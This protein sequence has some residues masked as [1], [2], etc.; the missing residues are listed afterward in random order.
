MRRRGYFRRHLAVCAAVSA[1]AL[2]VPGAALAATDGD[3]EPIPN[4]STLSE[5]AQLEGEPALLQRL[6]IPGSP[7]DDSPEAL[8]A[9]GSPDGPEDDLASL[10]AELA[11]AGT[12]E[13]AREARR[14][15]LDVLEGAPLDRAY[16]GIPLLNWNS[17]AKVK[18][19]PAGGSVTVRQVRFGEHLVSD[20]WLLRFDD[21]DAPFRIVYE[22]AELAGA[23]GG[24]LMP[25]PLL[26][27]PAAPLGG[28]HSIVEPLA[29]PGLATGTSETSR[30]HPDGEAEQTRVGL[31]RLTV[32]MPPP[33]HVHMLLDPSLKPG[34]E[35]LATLAPATPERIASAEAALGFSGD[36]PSEAQRREAISR[37][38]ARAPERQIWEALDALD[39]DAG[40][41]RAAAR[42]AAEGALPL[43]GAMRSRS[44]LPPGVTPEPGADVTVALLNNEAYVSRRGL[45]LEPG[46]ELRVAVVNHDGFPHRVNALELRGRRPVFGPTG[47]GEFDWGPAAG[48]TELAPGESATLTLRPSEGAFALW[49]GDQGTGDQAAATI[50]LDRGPRTQSIGFADDFTAPRHVAEDPDGRLW[51][52]LEGIDTI[53][54]ITPATDLQESGREEYPL[55]GGAYRPDSAQPPLGP[56]DVFVDGHG[57]VWVTLTLG[58]AIARIDPSLTEDGTSKGIRIYELDPCPPD[59]GDTVCREEFPPDAGGPT[60]GPLQL[61]GMLDAEG[62]TTLFFTEM[63]VDHIGVLRVAP[64]GAKLNQ[65]DVPCNCLV[66]LGIGLGADGAVWFTEG[67]TN[68]IGRLRLSRARPFTPSTAR[69][70]HFPIPF[71]TEVQDP[72]HPEPVFT[73]AP[74]S[75]AIDPEG[76]V[77]FTG[78]AVAKVAYLDPAQARAGTSIGFRSFDTGHSAYGGLTAPADLAADRGGT[79]YWTDEYGDIV[80]S[81][82]A[83]GAGRS[84]RPAERR[85]LTDSAMVDS[86]GNL[87]FLELGSNLLTRISG[88]SE[89]A[90]GPAPQPVLEALS[91]DDV[92]RGSRLREVSSVDVSVLRAGRVV[93]AAAAPVSGG[94]FEVGEGQW[95]GSSAGDALRGGDV[96]R[97]TPRAAH[98]RAAVEFTVA[99]LTGRVNS[100]RALTGSAR[101]G[102]DPLGGRLEAVVAGTPVR[103][104]IDPDDGS[105]AKVLNEGTGPG[106]TGT[107]SWA[108]ATAAAIFR[109][110]TRFPETAPPP[111]DDDDRDAGGPG[112]PPAGGGDD[113]G[114]DDDSWNDDDDRDDAGRPSGS[115]GRSCG[116][117]WL[118]GSGRGARVQLLG[119]SE[120]SVTRCLGRPA[121]RSVRGGVVRLRYP[122]RL[123]VSLRGGRAVGFELLA[124]GLRSAS[125]A[126]G[127]G[128][129]VNT[130]DRVLGGALKGRGPRRTAS[131]RAASGGRVRLTVRVSRGRTPRIAGLTAA[132]VE[133]RRG[134]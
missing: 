97:M 114:G 5:R 19:V 107:L 88:V 27:R 17:P 99:S 34:R 74:H 21:P 18:T 78:E 61:E 81:L 94:S 59:D 98:P 111:D 90:P 91:S 69:V 47:W 109:T 40:G 8:A 23:V 50:E 75:L 6:A 2:A 32:R 38:S 36:S 41:F 77:W 131:V 29:L 130:L 76:R 20:T 52:T 118:R 35:A 116:R 92:L 115:S 86:S 100:A 63:N 49:V 73:A 93:A 95:S 65:V 105:F 120:R 83:A 13:E 110:T 37:L 53:A 121:G 125:R 1:A 101:H 87:W 134:R 9:L 31:Q 30:F 103:A 12:P 106:A 16:G 129:K 117:H 133:R 60:R 11:A 22:V 62:N 26:G 39:P 127:L 64:D 112:G 102:G 33:R 71:G 124:P 51:I 45:H 48:T 10:L 104:E 85:S 57:I 96:V 46:A 128:M 44:Q 68:A 123:S 25:T 72:E 108:E 132:L 54:R 80:G 3:G 126:V 14:R 67:D 15:A 84:F 58:N 28:L 113:G 82:S 122:G 7:A 119:L 55:P 70:D 66:P 56:A 42:A 89:G 79:I 24:E 43:M 4:T